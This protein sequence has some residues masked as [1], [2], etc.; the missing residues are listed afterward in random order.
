MIAIRKPKNAIKLSKA[1]GWWGSIWREGLP[2]GN[3]VIGASVYGGAGNETIMITNANL[4]W[5]G[6]V[7]V[8]Q[9]V[10]D[11]VQQVRKTLDD[12]NFREAENIMQ[13]ALIQKGF[14]PTVGV[15]L[16]LCDLIVKQKFDKSITD[17]SRTLN[18]ENG[19]VSVSFRDGAS[20]YDRSLFVSRTQDLICY[21]ITKTGSK[22]ITVDLSFELHDKFYART[23]QSISQ[24]PDGVNI[25]Y[26]DY[27]MYF[28][29]RNDNGTDFGAVAK[30]LYYGG[31]QVVD[32]NK[33]I[34]ILDTDRVLVIIKPFVESSKDKE[35]K[36]LKPILAAQKLTYDKLIKEHTAVHSKL[37]GSVELDLDANNRDEFADKL[38]DIAQ[39]TG[40][41][42]LALIEKLWAYGRFLFI[43]GT[44]PS[45]KPM[46]PYGIWAGDYKAVD[47]HITVDTLQNQYSHILSG[48]LTEY[49][50]SIFAYYES[51]LDDLKKNA[52]RLYGCR[53][54][55]I[56]FVVAAGTGLIGS[57]DSS[58]LHNISCGGQIARF[59]YDYYL[60]TGDKKFLKEKAMPFM[61][62]VSIF[63]EE[64]FKLKADNL[65]ESSPSY[66]PHTTP[67]NFVME[68]TDGLQIARNSTLDFAVA[69]E[70][71]T[72][73]IQGSEITKLYPTEIS[74]WKDMLSKIP[75]YQINDDKTIKEYCD[76]KLTDN[77]TSPSTSVFYSVFPGIEIAKD[78]ANTTN[79]KDLSQNFLQTAK[80]RA[81]A[82]IQNTTSVDIV[83]FANT[84]ARLQDNNSA[85]EH[86]V[87][88]IKHMAMG[89]LIV[90]KNDWRG[91]G[92][93][94]TDSWATFTTEANSLITSAIQ[95]CILQSDSTSIT[96]LPALPQD[97]AKGE[98]NG[99]LTRIGAECDLSWD[100][101]RG[102]I[103][104]TLK[105]KNATKVNIYIPSIVKKISTKNIEF[106]P[107]TH[108]I[109]NL[110]LPSGKS[111]TIDMK[112]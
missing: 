35:W 14:R 79:N 36:A 39:T 78:R 76:Q 46:P 107:L 58:V 102:N 5:Q 65:Y 40:E 91:G 61:R 49:A 13:N 68:S 90:A 54:I 112:S 67:Q 15:P 32:P 105:A 62:D 12:N 56:P 74:K 16:P 30:I 52:S 93:G 19:E 101:K 92:V 10:A 17:Y 84:F 7:G 87:N 1:A 108:C 37:F 6:R 66:S 27:F 44:I 73:L 41:I 53:G 82:S 50:K 23:P 103:T 8:L 69:K 57:I 33:G 34:R 70:L 97:F 99:L 71:L 20:R 104:L 63:I 45:G 80:K 9:D 2:T 11:K 89:N 83:R 95:E 96:V 18:M 21:E 77:L 47:S 4:W 59:Y 94:Q 98:C 22:T 85:Y 88:A 51:H 25:K 28:S 38:L 75:N 31:K 106:D 26:E 72:N 3:G 29:A 24:I 109:S 43:S 111:V 60:Y 42:P 110:E 48:N 100:I 86:I 81:V 55:F 64:F